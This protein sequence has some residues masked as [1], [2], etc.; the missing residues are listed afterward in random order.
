MSDEALKHEALSFYFPSLDGIEIWPTVGGVNNYCD[1][2]KLANGER[3]VLRIYNN[4]KDYPRIIFEHKV[5]LELLKTSSLS[6]R[7]PTPIKSIKD[8]LTH[9]RLSNGFEATLFEYIP[10]RIH[11]YTL[12]PICMLYFYTHYAILFY[13]KL[14][15]LYTYIHIY[16]HIGELPKKTR[17]KEIGRA[18]GELVTALSNVTINETSPNPTFG[19][20]YKAHH[21]TTREIF[22]KQ[23]QL[24]DFD[25][26]SNTRIYINL[27]AEEVRLIEN[28]IAYYKS[29]NT[30]NSSM[31]PIQLIHAD[32]HYDNVLCDGD[33]VS[34]LLDFE[35]TVHDWRGM[36]IYSDRCI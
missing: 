29:N 13:T 1:H 32:L 25:V 26:N 3:F 22:F 11:V 20:I 28:K 35:F 9:V 10:G 14:I 2:V 5:L 30:T 21:A 7:I 24:P 6:C 23:I 27:L 18:S 36:Y 33:V 17:A 16:T 4:G 15:Y 12:L 34:G 19:D 31:L 8:G